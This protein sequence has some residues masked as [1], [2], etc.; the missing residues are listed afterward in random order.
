MSVRSSYEKIVIPEGL[1]PGK[2]IRA[3]HTGFGDQEY[4]AARAYF[5][6]YGIQLP[7][8]PFFSPEFQNP[9]FLRCFCCGLQN[10]G[11]TAIPG[12]GKRY[13]VGFRLL[14]VLCQREVV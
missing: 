13:L 6:F 5:D 8:I 7:A 1:V 4:E 3:V 2:M 10:R 9:L 11:L 14:S 12:R